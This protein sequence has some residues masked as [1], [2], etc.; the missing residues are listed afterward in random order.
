MYDTYNKYIGFLEVGIIKEL[1]SI[2]VLTKDEEEKIIK[3]L[4]H[5]YDI[6]V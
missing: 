5:K 4:E 6:E 2:G 1:A 3:Q